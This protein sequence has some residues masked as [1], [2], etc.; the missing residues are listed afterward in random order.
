MGVVG[1]PRS[2]HKKFLFSVEIDDCEV[3]WFESCS[4]IEAELGVV[5]QRE[6][7]KIVVA[8]QSP[9]LLKTTPVTL[10][11]GATD[12]RELWDW[13]EQIIDAA[14]DSGEPDD[15]YK[16]NV[17][18]VQRDRDGSEK[19]RYNLPKAWISKFKAAEWDAKAEEN[20]MQEVTIVYP[21][22]TMSQPTNG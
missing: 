4:A 17:A 10:T 3:A 13:W 8:D 21:Y 6:G 7:G 16:R 22:P 11:V 14:A 12:N 19:R 20:T 9:G 5:E 18:I 1:K 15:S 2:Y